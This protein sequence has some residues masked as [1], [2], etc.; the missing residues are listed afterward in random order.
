M[1]TIRLGIAVMVTLS[2][3]SALAD[4]TRDKA[5]AL[6]PVKN[7]AAESAMTF[8]LPE[9]VQRGEHGVRLRKDEGSAGS[10][11][12]L[13]AKEEARQEE[14]GERQREIWTSP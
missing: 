13:D 7:E 1:K 11:R 4:E 6:R 8:G 12:P 14:E 3:A 2:F 10:A 5:T 9:A